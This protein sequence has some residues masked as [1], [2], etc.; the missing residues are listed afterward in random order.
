MNW[1]YAL[2]G[3][4]EGPASEEYLTQLAASGTINGDTLVWAEGQPDWAPLSQVLPAALATA[5]VHAPQI[6]GFAV[7]AAQ[8][9]IYVQQM[10]EGV[11][12]N[13]P[14][15]LNY[16]G[17][18]IRFAAKL[19]DNLIIL[20]VLVL[21]LGVLGGILYAS[22][23]NID[24]NTPPGEPP[25][26]G[27]M[28]L[29]AAYYLV[30]FGLQVAYPAFFVAKYG[31]TWGKMALGLKVVNEDGSRV[32]TGRA[33]GRGFGELLNQFTCAIG[34]IIAGFDAEKRA[35]H[36]HICSTRVIQTR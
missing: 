33:I 21:F 20:V 7:P 31:A 24:P 10:R 9:D 30:A 1:Y 6:G 5:P 36:D 13:L 12:P 25:P 8:K 2:N 22:G 23:V 16:A 15:S 19:I 26:M 18:W 11:A 17:F 28:I 29:G 32:T 14:G 27:V 3:K 4:Q 35:L 34:Y